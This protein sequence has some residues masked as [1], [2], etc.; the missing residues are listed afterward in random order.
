MMEGEGA[1]VPFITIKAIRCSDVLSWSVW[2]T[3]H[4]CRAPHSLGAQHLVLYA[5]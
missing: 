4:V 3:E 5:K 2:L 1:T